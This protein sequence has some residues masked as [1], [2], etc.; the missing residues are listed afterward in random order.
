MR[1]MAASSDSEIHF[2]LQSRKYFLPHLWL[3]IQELVLTRNLNNIISHKSTYHLRV[4][5]R[6]KFT[7]RYLFAFPHNLFAVDSESQIL[8][9]ASFASSGSTLVLKSSSFS[10]TFSMLIWTNTI[11]IWSRISLLS[12]WDHDT[13]HHITDHR[14]VTCHAGVWRVMSPSHTPALHS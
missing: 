1:K 7:P 14:L 10:S 12:S 3:M 4:V 11:F 6:E 13:R 2:H 8:I 9:S 5:R